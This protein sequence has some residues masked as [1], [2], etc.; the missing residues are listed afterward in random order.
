MELT[1]YEKWMAA[2]EARKAGDGAAP[3][4]MFANSTHN[5]VFDANS[6]HANT[7]HKKEATKELHKKGQ[8]KAAFLLEVKRKKQRDALGSESNHSEKQPDED[9]EDESDFDDVY[10]LDAKHNSGNADHMVNP[11]YNEEGALY[12]SATD[13]DG[14]AERAAA[15]AAITRR[16]KK[17]RKA[18]KQSKRDCKQK[19]ESRES[20]ITT[21]NIYS[22]ANDAGGYYDDDNQWH[23]GVFA[24]DGTF[25]PGYYDDDYNWVDLEE[26]SF[27]LADF[28]DEQGDFYYTNPAAPAAGQGYEGGEVGEGYGDE[29]YD[30]NNDYYGDEYGNEERGSEMVSMQA[31][32]THN[33]MT[34]DQDDTNQYAGYDD[35]V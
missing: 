12:E 18:K 19:E 15:V 13:D 11:M 7:Y 17:E 28:T 25:Y 2:E 24:P 26:A 8:A 27:S 35:A 3:V 6:K 5:P 9:I 1:P 20:S 14:Q 31:G 30:Q 10:D 32:S 22:E 4:G 29:G 34:D 23:N 21:R 33:P 16:E